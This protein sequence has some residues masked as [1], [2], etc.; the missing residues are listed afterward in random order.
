MQIHYMFNHNSWFACDFNSVI[1]FIDNVDPSLL[2]VC[3]KQ[4]HTNLIQPIILKQAG[5]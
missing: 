4:T 5:N 3:S 1:V 2:F